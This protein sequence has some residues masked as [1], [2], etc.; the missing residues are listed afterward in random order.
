MHEIMLKFL[1]LLDKS[2]ANIFNK[3]IKRLNNST[4]RQKRNRWS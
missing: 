1:M 3:Q 2:F 4:E